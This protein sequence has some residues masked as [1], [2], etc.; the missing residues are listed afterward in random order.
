MRF[1]HDLFQGDTDLLFDIGMQAT[2]EFRDIGGDAQP[3]SRTYH[4]QT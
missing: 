2:D 3:M 4:R 1:G